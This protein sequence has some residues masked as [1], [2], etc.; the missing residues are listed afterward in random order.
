MGSTKIKI[1]QIYHF[2]EL[3]MNFKS[4]NKIDKDFFFSNRQRN[5]EHSW[6]TDELC[7]PT[8]ILASSGVL[9]RRP[10]SA[11]NEVNIN[12]EP[13]RIFITQKASLMIRLW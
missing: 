2:V 11:Q 7:Q 1:K 10:G 13:L 8:E 5:E 3:K 6:Y 12:I 9:E 4:E